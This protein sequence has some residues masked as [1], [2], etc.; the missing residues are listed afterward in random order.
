MK[1]SLIIVFAFFSQTFAFASG[2]MTISGT[3][4]GRTET[5]LSIKSR[6][7]IFV[8]NKSALDADQLKSTSALKSGNAIIVNVPMIGIAEVKSAKATK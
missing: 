7:E 5:T 4:Y 6:D 2:V 8:I 3:V 1:L